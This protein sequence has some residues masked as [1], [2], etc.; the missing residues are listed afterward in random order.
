MGECII[1]HIFVYFVP[2]SLS[3]TRLADMYIQD[4]DQTKYVAPT[5]TPY[6]SALA[7]AKHAWDN[8]SR[9]GYGQRLGGWWRWWRRRG[10]WG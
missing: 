9:Q 2:L 7:L 3:S 8:F 5:P 6:K 1:H 4:G 10:V